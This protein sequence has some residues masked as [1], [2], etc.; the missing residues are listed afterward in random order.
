MCWHHVH[1]EDLLAEAVDGRDQRDD[2]HEHARDERQQPDHR[3]PARAV[4]AAHA[5][6]AGH[7]ERD[8][9]ADE[10]DGSGVERPRGV[11]SHAAAS[12]Q[13][14][15]GA[16]TRGV[17]PSDDALAAL[18]PRAARPAGAAGRRCGRVTPCAARAAPRCRSCGASAARAAPC[19]PRAGVA[20]RRAGGR[21]GAR[22]VAGRLRRARARPRPRAEVPRRAAG[23]RRDGGADRRGRAA[24]PAGARRGARAGAQ[25]PAPRARAAASTTPDRSRAW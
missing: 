9:E 1:H 13:M 3:C 25:P 17:R 15:T 24:G 7:V 2:E 19:R 18:A 8:G 22:L 14:R 16:V 23:R 10:K 6:P 20:A 4:G 21:A 11:R 12:S 5:P